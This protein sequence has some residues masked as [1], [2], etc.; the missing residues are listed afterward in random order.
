[1]NKNNP[2]Y[3]LSYESFFESL[4]KDFY[5]EVKAAKF[6]QLQLRFRNNLLLS[7]IGLKPEEIRDS[8]FLDFL[9]RFQHKQYGL[10]SKYH[11]YQFGQ[12][13]PNLGDGRGFLYAQ[14]RGVDGNLYDFG[15]KGSGQTPYSQ[16]RDGRLTLKGG[17]RE[18]LASELLHRLGVKT[19]RCISL[20]ET[21]EEL[22]REDNSSHRGAVMVRVSLSHI[23]F[24]TFEYLEYHD[25]PDLIKKLLDY[26]IN[27]YYPF[28]SKLPDIYKYLY[29]YSELVERI[30]HMVAK[31]MAAGFC[32]GVLNTD[33]MSI[34]GESF[35]YGPWQFI[36]YYNPNFTAANFDEFGRY[37]YRNQ[38]Q[39]CKENLRLLQ[40]PLA[41]VIPL[42]K[43]EE[44][45]D[46]FPEQY[47][48]FYQQ[49]MLNK[50]GF[51]T[52]SPFEAE[53][54]LSLTL[55]LLLQTRISYSHFFQ[56]LSEK[57]SP[58]W[59]EEQ[60]LILRDM[61]I[62]SRTTDD[63][64]WHSWSHY[65]QYLLS[66]QS[67]EEIQ[68]VHNRLKVHNPPVTLLNEDVEAI[69]QQIIEEDNWEKFNSVI[70]KIQQ[71]AIGNKK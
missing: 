42:N 4:G 38:P 67:N 6:P 62:K 28:L 31:W 68:L 64:I 40:N 22:S 35:D 3:K 37:S 39:V 17:I 19:S 54:L 58:Q 52:L 48:R 46:S 10:A 61:K 21:G 59:G 65:Y 70:Q 18:V 29:F 34:T 2:F 27:Y 44:I 15:T 49:F 23:R 69:W 33:N 8:H 60:N 12:Y 11:G 43:M 41:A 26:V 47:S 20:I 51:K 9:G 50:L 32:H 14:F 30:A 53:E 36:D 63:K 57:F 1:M 13:N 56:R 7:K 66:Q 55:K 71:K 25:R 16:G 45:L 24:G 5:E